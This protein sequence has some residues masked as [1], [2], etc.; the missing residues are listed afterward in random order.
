MPKIHRT[1]SRFEG[2]EIMKRTALR[3]RKVPLAPAGLGPAAP[4]ED[5]ADT[6]DDR[7]SE[8]LVDYEDELEAVEVV[9]QR[10]IRSVN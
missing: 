8:S 6:F 7:V 1:T 9:V 2:E 5:L 4:R 3:T 10:M